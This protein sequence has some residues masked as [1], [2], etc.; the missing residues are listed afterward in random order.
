MTGEYV[1]SNKQQSIDFS[2]NHGTFKWELVTSDK[3]T[4]TW[5]MVQWFDSSTGEWYPPAKPKFG[6]TW[7][8]E[9]VCRSQ[10]VTCEPA[11]SA[12]EIVAAGNLKPIDEIAIGQS[13][14]VRLTFAKDP[15]TEISESVTVSSSDGTAQKIRVTGHGRIIY[16]HPIL[17]APSGK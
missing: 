4:G 15:G 6:G 12:V 14:R 10:E 9:L 2:D 11:L 16:S 17:V 3:F 8:G 1:W 13:F 5:T 7:H